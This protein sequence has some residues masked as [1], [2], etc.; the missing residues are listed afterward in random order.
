MNG[1]APS[2][3]VLMTAYNRADYIAASI[4]S[5]LAQTFADFELVVVDDKSTDATVA[6]VR[7][8][9]SDPRI[10]LIVNERNLGDY[11]NRNH[12]ATFARAEFLKYHDSDDVMYP[13]CLEVMVDGLRGAPGAA[14]ALT[15]S[16]GWY[17]A[18]CPM[19]LTPRLA[20][21]REYLGS[22]LFHSG[23]A[24]ALF[25]RDA[26]FALGCFPIGNIHADLLFW[27]HAC[28]RVSIVLVAGDLFWYRVHDE[29][30]IREGWA[31]Y[32]SAR[33]EAPRW[34]AIDA[35]ESPLA[36]AERPVAKR[37]QA[38]GLAKRIGGDLRAG[39]WR[40]AWFR[41][42]QSGLSVGDWLR[43]LRAPRRQAKAGSPA[44]GTPAAA[45]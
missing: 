45:A 3:S 36:L 9:L 37:N 14:L 13:H 25:R 23:P 2:V 32:E 4:E 34:R 17:G 29:Q 20:Y 16:R 43:Y 19:V 12:A 6:V 44:P 30:V 38:F 40:L 33:L 27:L 15:S 7:R 42:R 1:P 8:Y 10:R 22:G 24:C 31:K 21:Q 35:P 5:V 39:E 26:F 41:F 18:P 28:A 11:P